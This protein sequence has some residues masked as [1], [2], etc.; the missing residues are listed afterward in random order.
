MDFA[1][2][3]ETITGIFG[4]IDIAALVEAITGIIAGIFG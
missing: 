2:I 1:G 4:D 3:I